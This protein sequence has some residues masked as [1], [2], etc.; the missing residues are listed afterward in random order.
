M[1]PN[2]HRGRMTTDLAL[3]YLGKAAP[4]AGVNAF[5]T[6]RVLQRCERGE[7]TLLDAAELLM[8]AAKRGGAGIEIVAAGTSTTCTFTRSFRS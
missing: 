6:R 4:L 2:V 3:K 7:I 1:A 8:A 5:Y